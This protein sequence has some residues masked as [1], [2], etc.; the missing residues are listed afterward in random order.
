MGAARP[1]L[2]TWDRPCSYLSIL[3]AP[4]AHAGAAV[5]ME[6]LVYVAREHG[7]TPVSLQLR[8]DIREV[9]QV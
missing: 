7:G 2:L 1:A 4:L 9:C 3:L 5:C 8:L 6:R